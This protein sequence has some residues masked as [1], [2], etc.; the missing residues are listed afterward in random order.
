MSPSYFVQL[1]FANNTG[2]KY[3]KTDI[4]NGK[5]FIE[6]DIYESV[7]VD[8]QS[9]T[10][11]VK[12]INAS[13]KSKNVNLDLTGF[14]V[15]KVSNMYLS[16]D[17]RG[18]CNEIGQTYVVPHEKELAAG[19]SVE[20]KMGKYSVNVVRIAYGDN[21]GSSFYVLPDTVP[22]SKGKFVPIA[23]KAG[24]LGGIGAVI[25][26]AVIVCVTVKLIKKRRNRK[27]EEI[28]NVKQ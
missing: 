21:D 7:T 1:L 2:N 5:T 10:I 12:L 14:N 28:E 26:L 18:A 11:Y 13:G 9:Q 3:I 25:L 20:V 23:V 17:Y 24:I 16:E 22:V 19:D 27:L 8:E 4:G 15:N 6:K